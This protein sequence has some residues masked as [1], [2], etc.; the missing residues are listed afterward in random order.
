QTE[1]V[2]DLGDRADGGPRVARGRL[3]V[4]RDRRRQ[5]LDEVDVGLV[6]L[7]EELPRV[8][9]E[10]LDVPALPL[11]VDRV[12][13]ERRFPRAGEPGEDDQLLARKREFDVLEV[14]LTGAADDDR[15]AHLPPG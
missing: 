14:V 12:E 2:V 8:R 6:H 9:R 5:T 7:T 4:D 3:L 1:V 11:G 13:R 15:V 10:R